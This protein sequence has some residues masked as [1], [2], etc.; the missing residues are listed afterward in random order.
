MCSDVR[1][2]K[3]QSFYIQKR[4][5]LYFIKD[6][7]HKS[8]L[9]TINN[10]CKSLILNFFISIFLEGLVTMLQAFKVGWTRDLCRCTS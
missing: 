5:D 3:F 9:S 6:I 4:I 2:C 7:N 10:L 1:L 8:Y